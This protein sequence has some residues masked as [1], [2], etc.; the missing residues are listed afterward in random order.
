MLFFPGVEGREKQ[1]IQLEVGIDGTLPESLSKS[2]R[3][4]TPERNCI[5]W[6]E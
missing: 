3:L 5:G 2:R 4:S 1:F 6:P